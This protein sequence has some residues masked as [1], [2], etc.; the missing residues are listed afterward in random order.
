MVKGH[1]QCWINLQPWQWQVYITLVAISLFLIPA[2]IIASCY[3]V[4]VC[5]I[6]Q[7]GRAMIPMPK[8]SNKTSS[9][10]TT[11]F[12]RSSSGGGNKCVVASQLLIT[13]SSCSGHREHS[14]EHVHLP[15][16]ARERVETSQFEGSDSA[17]EDQKRQNDSGHRFR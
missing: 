17:G 12:Q 14:C 16:R 13:L 8:S 11:M 10:R 6:W 9:V 7:K 5:I 2:V 1:P 4:I 3:S 15:G